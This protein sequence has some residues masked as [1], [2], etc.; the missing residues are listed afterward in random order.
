MSREQNLTEAEVAARPM[1]E[2]FMAG[3]SNS[4]N[5]LTYVLVGGA[6]YLAY[7]Y[8]TSTFPWSVAAAAP[9]TGTA[10]P[11]PTTPAAPVVA[12]VPPT[13]TQQLQT[14]A[15][16][17]ASTQLD[18]DQWSYYWQQLNLPAVDGGKWNTLFFPSGR[19]P[20][21]TAAPTMTASAYVS[22]LQGAGLA[23]YKRGMGQVARIP[24]PI[25]FG[26]GF[27]KYDLGDLRKAGGR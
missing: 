20:S 14:A 19:P 10:P 21:G 2:N 15:S 1:E 12:Y 18:A 7:N 27:G 3:N 13:Q 25:F 8:F 11:T 16:G 23:G 17:T 22:A 9:A 6:A 4:S 26:R 24:V 5:L